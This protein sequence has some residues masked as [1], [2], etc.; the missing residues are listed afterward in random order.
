MKRCGFRLRSYTHL[1]LVSTFTGVQS[2]PRKS[3][4]PC[5]GDWPRALQ[6]SSITNA[7]SVRVTCSLLTRARWQ[8]MWP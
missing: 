7:C 5:W 1:R 4:L 3:T 6:M 8:T 2:Y